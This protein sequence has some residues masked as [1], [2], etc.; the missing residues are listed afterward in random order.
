MIADGGYALTWRESPERAYA[1]LVEKPTQHVSTL[2]PF[3]RICCTGFFNLSRRFFL[4]FTDVGGIVVFCREA[5]KKCG[6]TFATP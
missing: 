3:Y 2:P 1:A 5:M 6:I 4:R